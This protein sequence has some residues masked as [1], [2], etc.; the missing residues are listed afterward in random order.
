[1]FFLLDTAS[2]EPQTKEQNIPLSYKE[3]SWS[4]I[5]NSTVDYSFEVLKSGVIID[6]INLM[7]KSYFVFGRLAGCD[8]I[9]AHPTISR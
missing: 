8:V 7:T 4:G 5:P 2:S 6:K 3:P 1:M 9:M